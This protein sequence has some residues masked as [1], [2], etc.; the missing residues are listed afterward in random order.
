MRK[1]VKYK[2]TKVIKYMER[3][4]S[5]CI[6]DLTP[7]QIIIMTVSSQKHLKAHENVHKI[8]FLQVLLAYY[9]V[10]LE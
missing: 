8:F 10:Y 1:T 2:D 6:R 9:G 4:L 7:I 3:T 5:F